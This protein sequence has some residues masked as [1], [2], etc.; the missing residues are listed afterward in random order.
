[1]NKPH[2][3]PKPP[4]DPAQPNPQPRSVAEVRVELYQN[5]MGAI[6]A[7]LEKHKAEHGIEGIELA[8]ITAALNGF[9]NW[10]GQNRGFKASPEIGLLIQI[11]ME[12]IPKA[13]ADAEKK[14]K[15]NRIVLVGR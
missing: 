14:V 6:V 10:V 2:G 1:M 13:A 15:N 4:A 8:T 5:T 9:A 3:E 11:G 12:V 7:V